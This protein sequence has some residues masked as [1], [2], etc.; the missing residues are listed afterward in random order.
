MLPAIH[1]L[2]MSRV[3]G[4]GGYR[5]QGFVNRPGSEALENQAESIPPAAYTIFDDDIVTGGT[6]ACAQELLLEFD[7]EV[8]GHLSLETSN[9]GIDEVADCRDFLL[10][11]FEAGLVL[12]LPDGS[13]GRAPYAL[14]F[15]DPSVRSSIPPEQAIEFSIQVW[16]ANVE[17]F[18]G[19]GMTVR[20]LP[21]PARDTMLAAGHC[22]NCKLRDVCQI[23]V[24]RLT[25]F[26]CK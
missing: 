8:V 18:N 14:P 5:Q 25:E 3:F 11:A 9:G 22:W 4:M 19:T 13:Q 6:V 17:F 7:R 23:Y 16:K 20:D 2:A 26:L 15:V 24:D 12:D 1:N 10:G 21:K